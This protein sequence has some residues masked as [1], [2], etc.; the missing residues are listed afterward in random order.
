MIQR[1]RSDAVLY[2]I[3]SDFEVNKLTAE[4]MFRRP[5]SLWSRHGGYL[6]N[7]YGGLS[8]E[9]LWYPVASRLALGVEV[10]YAKQRDFDMLFGFQD[11]DV[12]TGHASAYYDLGNGFTTQVDVGRYLAKDWGATFGLDREFNNGFKIG[13]YFT[14]TDVSFDD[15]GEGS[16]DKG[17]RFSVPLSWLTGEPSRDTV[18]RVIQPVTRDGGRG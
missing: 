15:F 11:Y 17:L 14:L 5:R 8:G 16:F 13:G 4:Y 6:E 1:V 3:E 9:L 2:A 12:V 7:M 18:S 10:N